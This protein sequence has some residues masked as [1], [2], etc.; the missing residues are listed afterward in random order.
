MAVLFDLEQ[1]SR[2]LHLESSLN[3][4]VIADVHTFTQLLQRLRSIYDCTFFD[5]TQRHQKLTY[6]IIDGL[7]AFHWD[8]IA[9]GTYS[10]EFT[11]LISLLSKIMGQFGC[12]VITTSYDKSFDTGM[13]ARKITPTTG[14]QP[15]RSWSG[16]PEMFFEHVEHVIY[17]HT[18]RD[19]VMGEHWKSGDSRP[20][21]I[22]HAKLV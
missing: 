5:D 2:H 4:T 20:G 10:E 14:K 6:L 15:Y 16:L 22:E 1:S 11:S 8:L 17:L 21:I 9:Q 19:G 7:S 18:L 12:S 3:T 13:V